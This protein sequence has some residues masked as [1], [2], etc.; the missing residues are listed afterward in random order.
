[1]A[2]THAFTSGVADGGDAAL[3]RPSN[4]N[5]AHVGTMTWTV[6]SADPAPAVKGNGYLCDTSAAAFT[7]TLPAAAA[8]GDLI[9]IID[10]SGTFGSK[11]LTIARNGLLIMK[12]AEDMV[13]NINNLN[14][15]LV[16]ADADCGWRII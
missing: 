15:S 3:V 7:L 11:N 12:I 6:I 1:M 13:V 16:Y 5:A 14:F 10:E 2:I 9:G 4:W 8:A